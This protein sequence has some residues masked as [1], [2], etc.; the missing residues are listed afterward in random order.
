[1]ILLSAL[2]AKALLAAPITFPIS[3]TDVP[4]IHELFVEQLFEFH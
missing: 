4:V 3:F 1:M 2:P